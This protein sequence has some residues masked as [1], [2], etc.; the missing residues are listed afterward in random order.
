MKNFSV[1]SKKLA[2]AIVFAPARSQVQITTMSSWTN[3]TNWSQG[4]YWTNSTNWSQ[5]TYWTNSSNWGQ[6]SS[7]K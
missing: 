2:S 3:S 4:T 6:G 7:G 5:G 1:F